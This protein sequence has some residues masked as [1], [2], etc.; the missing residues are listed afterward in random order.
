MRRIGTASCVAG[1]LLV[2]SSAPAGAA[3]LAPISADFGTQ[4]VGSVSSPRVFTLTPELLDI[5][6]LTVAT[7]GQFKQT[8][9]CGAVLQFVSGPCTISV[10]FA[11]TDVG[12]QFGSLTTTT[13]L[14][15]PSASLRGT[16]TTG[17]DKS[18][19]EVKCKAAG[20]KKKKK[21]KKQRAATAAKKKK[22]KKK[23][24][25]KKKKKG[26]K[27]RKGKKK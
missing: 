25:C 4:P 8:N 21:G 3:T 12:N 18:K 7:T 9:T 11:P 20:K 26:K 16:A 19:G 24:G 10:T 1:M 27:K 2:F 22:G 6:P 5:L 13:L 17:A 14:G 23:K 15:G